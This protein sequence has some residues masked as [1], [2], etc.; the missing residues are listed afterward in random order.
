MNIIYEA[1]FV[2]GPLP[3]TLAKDIEFKHITT[4]FKPSI[5]H[6]H[7]YGLEAKFIITEY[8]NDGINEGYKVDLISCESNELRELF[9]TISIPHITLSISANG[10]AV[11][12]KNLNF[13]PV[14]EFTVITKFGGFLNKPIFKEE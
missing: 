11:N 12:T 7:L 10:K 9:E 5:S 4:E 6:E 3:S 8:G 13:E 2:M 14:S 1:F